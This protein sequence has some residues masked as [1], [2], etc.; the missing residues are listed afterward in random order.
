[1]KELMY[2]WLVKDYL[3]GEVGH[4]KAVLILAVYH[5]ILDVL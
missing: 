3:L 2:R 1:M 4:E 5:E